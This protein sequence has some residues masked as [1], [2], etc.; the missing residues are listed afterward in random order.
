MTV[1]VEHIDAVL[2]THRVWGAVFFNR[3]MK[4]CIECT[5]TIDVERIDNPSLP[6]CVP[7]SHSR[8][9]VSLATP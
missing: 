6:I 2:T 8:P 9:F 5:R 4:R 3:N 7:V 1:R